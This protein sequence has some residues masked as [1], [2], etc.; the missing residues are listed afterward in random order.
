MPRV[1]TTFDQV[2]RNIA[3]YDENVRR[4]DQ[5]A[6]RIKQHPAWYAIRD[7]A[8]RWLFGPSKFIGYEDADA[9]SYLAAYNRKD[10]KETE[11]ALS[12]WFSQ[13]NP[14]TAL[15]RELRQA[16]ER[17]AQAYGKTPNLRWRVSVPVE[18]LVE[19]RGHAPAFVADERI[20]FDPEICGGRPHIKGTR[21]RVSD[22]IAA[23][24]EGETPAELL[25]DFPYLT[26][27]DI[28]AALRYAANAIDHRVLVA[29]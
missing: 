15:G 13:V 27:A 7:D 2:V 11:P 18:Y 8:G 3:T 24:A 26:E 19:R 1:V 17:F 10:G 22:I 28:A 4:H 21:V 29:A 14:Q 9:S 23:L 5:L 20:V 6:A 16:F 25:A 12:R